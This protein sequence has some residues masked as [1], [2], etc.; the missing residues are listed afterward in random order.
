MNP[1]NR[2]EALREIQLDL[3]EGADMVMVKPS[4]ALFRVLLEK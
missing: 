2:V 1:A 3:S 4:N